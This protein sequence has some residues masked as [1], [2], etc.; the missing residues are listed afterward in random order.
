[1][2][3]TLQ[4]LGRFV[5]QVGRRFLD[6][7]CLNLAASL[8]YTTLLS[9]VPIVTIAVTVIAAFPVFAEFTRGVDEFFAENMLPPTVA[10]AITGHI[11]Q[12]ASSAAQLTAVGIIFLA[13][14]AI[15]LMMTIERAF[16]AIWQVKHH[17]PLMF[18]ILMY[19]GVLT[20]GPL[21]I[22]AS[23]TITSYLV[24]MSLGLARE[25]PG[26]ATVLLGLVP[27]LLTAV[28]FALVYCAVP[29]RPVQLRHAVIGGLTAAA[30]F[31]LMKRGFA[32]YVAKFP[33]YAL[34]YGAFAT[35]PI[36]LIWIY[37]SWVVAL[38]GAVIAALLPDLRAQRGPGEAPAGAAFRDALEILRVL[39]RAQQASR[40]RRTREI[41]A[42][43][44]V[45]REAGERLLEDMA[46][47]GW[48]ARVVGDRWTLACDP[49]AVR[50]VDVYKRLVFA[51][52]A[53]RPRGGDA[54]LDDIVERAAAGV[55]HTIAVPIRTLV[56]EPSALQ[57][58][59]EANSPR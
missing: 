46:A 44:R 33:S 50:I 37:L 23:L 21:L 39:I 47:A 3:S 31:E 19:W 59:P 25:I 32:F 36:F 29:N 18:R 8:T 4:L 28:A 49:S 53:G 17:R 45:P 30:M 10:K 56:E 2:R 11:E 15:M 14:T 48:V 43:A 55:E 12:F 54:G 6:D 38:L 57:G 22:G 27:I 16:N 5:A 52:A 9:L 42:E 24:G 13:V 7:D 40:T 35:V 41:V 58:S 34:V 26:A 20:L 1:M 51:P